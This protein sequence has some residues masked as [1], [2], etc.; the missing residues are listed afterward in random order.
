LSFT[1]GVIPRGSG[2]PVVVI[3]VTPV[4]IGVMGVMAANADTDAANVNAKESL[5]GRQGDGGSDQGKRAYGSRGK[6]MKSS[7]RFVDQH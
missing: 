2:L 3:G 1:P 4:V 7:I 6:P 5:G